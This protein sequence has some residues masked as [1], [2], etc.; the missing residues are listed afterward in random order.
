MVQLGACFSYKADNHEK[1]SQAQK[2]M[3]GGDSRVGVKWLLL[4]G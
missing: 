2:M 3:G 1:E 4:E